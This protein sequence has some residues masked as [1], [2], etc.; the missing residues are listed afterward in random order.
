MEIMVSLENAIGTQEA[1]K[2]LGVS[3]ARMHLLRV[4]LKKVVHIGGRF[5]YDRAEVESFAKTRD[6][7]RGRR[8]TNHK[9]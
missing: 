4:R 7:S 1:A 9:P 6:R 3:R 5:V 8:R 2:I